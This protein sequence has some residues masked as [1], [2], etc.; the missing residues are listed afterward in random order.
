MK[1]NK[2]I[3]FLQKKAI[4]R[5]AYPVFFLATVGYDFAFRAMYAFVG[6]TT[7]FAWTPCLFTLCWAAILTGIACLLPHVV[8]QIFMISITVLNA[9]LG[10]THAVFYHIFGDFFSVTDVLYASEG[11]AFFDFAY[12]DIRKLMWI[13][14]A[15]YVLLVVLAAISIKKSRFFVLK[16]LI[17]LPLIAVGVAGILIIGAQY[18]YTERTAAISW[19]MGMTEDEP[20]TEHEQLCQ[21][22]YDFTDTGKML[23]FTGLYQYT[24]RNIETTLRDM[25]FGDSAKAREEIN[26]YSAA[27]EAKNE[28]NDM[29]GIF[30]DKN[31]ILIMVESLDTWMLDEDFTP[32]ITA[33]SK[34]GINFTNNY[35]PLWL[36]AGTFSTEFVSLTGLIL[37]ETVA[38]DNV[39]SDNAYPYALPNLF[40][41]EGYTVNSFHG[42]NP[43]I[44]NRG[45][46]HENLGFLK[47]HNW[48]DMGMK[49]PHFDTE[50][51]NAYDDFTADEPFCS[52]I[53]TISGHG[54]YAK[55]GGDY[56][57]ISE[58]NYDRAKAAMDK[59]SFAADADEA[60]RENMILALSQI[61]ETDDFIGELVERLKKDG[62]IENTVLALYGDHFSKYL[63]NTDYLMKV[64]GVSNHNLLCTTPFI[65]YAEWMEPLAVDKYVSSV[66]IYPTLVNLFGLDSDLSK[67]VGDDAFSERGG[68]VYWPTGAY[69]TSD[70][71]YHENDG[72]ATLSEVR[73][74]LRIS[75]NCIKYNYFLES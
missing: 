46:I 7:L 58:R 37:P 3:G 35:T 66:D 13:S 28:V 42:S 22:Y 30:K 44:Y 6:G 60:T 33:L 47:Y 27:N 2:L 52:Y 19:S 4:S 63:S 59:K 51:I 56:S 8:K 21:S 53:I 15:M 70:G 20:L 64:K 18:N 62:L 5:F 50:M 43:F 1:K 61:M 69:L 32:N 38:S 67:F 45:A 48:S 40:K 75:R 71:V 29:T 74:K 57:E 49:N 41:C 10:L 73:K 39:Y 25:Y 34:G 36:S 55:E 9:L 54:P 65:I 16:R 14:A 11:A 72:D 23:P 31:L 26:E 24:Y 68:V 12:L 17:A